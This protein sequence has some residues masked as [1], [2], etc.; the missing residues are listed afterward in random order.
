MLCCDCS[1]WM[2]NGD[3]MPTR[4]ESQKDALGVISNAKT[5]QNQENTIGLISMGGN[6][7]ADVLVN[8]T[9]DVGRVLAAAD[10]MKIDGKADILVA[11]QTSQ[12][13]LKHKKNKKPRS[14]NY[15][16]CWKSC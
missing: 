5:E 13:A 10:K 8:C 1:E 2:R 3:L 14:K 12:L 16:I 11:L 4:F 15:I 7:K 9:N 6:G